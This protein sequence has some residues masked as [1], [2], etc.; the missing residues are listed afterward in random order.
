MPNAKI[1]TGENQD[2]GS[3]ERSGLIGTIRGSNLGGV[4]YFQVQETIRK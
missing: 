3:E 2:G 1:T 4:S